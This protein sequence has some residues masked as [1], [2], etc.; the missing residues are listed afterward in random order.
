MIYLNI[1]SLPT[2]GWLFPSGA[3]D[4]INLIFYMVVL[5]ISI[6]WVIT[7]NFLTQERVVHYL[8]YYPFI[9]GIHALFFWIVGY[10][11]FGL[12]GVFLIINIILTHRLINS[13]KMSIMI[14]LLTIVKTLFLV[15]FTSL[16]FLFWFRNQFTFS[17]DT[18]VTVLFFIIIYFF[19]AWVYEVKNFE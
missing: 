4:F 19:W 8:F 2:L 5:G 1:V 16:V 10:Q 17:S 14:H 6:H 13:W 18:L 7:L 9:L 11:F 12:F 15:V 3:F